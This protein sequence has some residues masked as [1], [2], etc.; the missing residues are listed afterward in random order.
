[1]PP[2]AVGEVAGGRDEVDLNSFPDAWPDDPARAAGLCGFGQGRD[3]G[4]RAHLVEHF[5]YMLEFYATAARHGR[6]AVV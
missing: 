6:S 1:V 5:A 4:L 3:G 2:G